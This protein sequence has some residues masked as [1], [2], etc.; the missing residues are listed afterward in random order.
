MRICHHYNASLQWTRKCLLSGPNNL[1]FV[2]LWLQADAR[3]YVSISAARYVSYFPLCNV[4]FSYTCDILWIG[5]TSIGK[6]SSCSYIYNQ[7]YIIPTAL[8]ELF[9]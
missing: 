7:A 9:T 8:C 5:K 4:L 1:L 3:R 2:V 6:V